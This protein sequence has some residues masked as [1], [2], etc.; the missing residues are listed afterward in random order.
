MNS[1]HSV[2]QP[3]KKKG[4][5]VVSNANMQLNREPHVLF[6]GSFW[7]CRKCWF[8]S[9][10]P[11]WKANKMYT[12][13]TKVLSILSKQEHTNLLYVH[14]FWNF[15]LGEDQAKANATVHLPCGS[16]QV[17]AVTAAQSV[18]PEQ[19]GILEPALKFSRL[20]WPSCGI[21]EKWKR[22]YEKK[23][24]Y[25]NIKM[26]HRRTKSRDNW[27]EKTPRLHRW[28]IKVS[29]TTFDIVPHISFAETCLSP[30][31]PK[32]GKTVTLTFWVSQAAIAKVTGGLS[33][34]VLQHITACQL[35]S[36]HR[37]NHKVDDII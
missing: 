33:F 7:P 3:H 20:N 4:R 11:R 15:T 6:Q 16:T 10:I 34:A 2:S 18:S 19:D 31:R 13:W 29:T 9:I 32:T 23:A 36:V 21:I 17:D 30:D 25:R 1:T 5:R 27:Y 24:G 12:E 26:L 35:V 28:K 37:K 8:I 22:I 14:P